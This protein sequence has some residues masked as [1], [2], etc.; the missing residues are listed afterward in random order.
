MNS[1]AERG[2]SEFLQEAGMKSHLPL[3]PE[4]G[5]GAEVFGK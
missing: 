3:L 2:T 5:A 1:E 4:L